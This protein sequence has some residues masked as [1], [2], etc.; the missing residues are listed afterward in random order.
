MERSLAGG[1][2][3]ELRGFQRLV[4]ATAGVTFALVLVGGIVRVSDSGLGC[5]AAGSGSEGWPLCG[6]QVVPLIG[7][8]NR[9]V[10]FSHRLLAAVVVGLI[11]W[12]AW[13]AYKHLPEQRWA[14][15]GSLIAGVLVLCQAVLGGFTVENNLHELLVAAHLMLAMILL[16]I[17][18]WLVVRARREQ[19]LEGPHSAELAAATPPRGLRTASA[20]AAVLVLA[21]IVAGGYVAGTEKEGVENGPV[22]GAH[23]ACGEQFPGCA[24]EGVLPFGESRLIDIQLTHRVLVYGATLSVLFLLGFAYHRGSRSQLLALTA[25]VL[26]AQFSLGVLNVMLGK[27]ATLVVAHLGTGTLLWVTVLL[28]AYTLAWVRVPSRATARPSKAGTPVAAA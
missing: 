15:R 28:I 21:A 6:G 14:F 7:D 10:E 5:G 18:L 3:G 2:A 19:A 24:N 13:R 27:H 16:G 1:G 26:L 23:L 9:I 8:L 11:V 12:M 20:V 22:G 25:A 17:L 4:E